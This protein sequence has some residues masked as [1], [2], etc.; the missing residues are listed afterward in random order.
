MSGSSASVSLPD[1]TKLFPLPG[2]VLFPSGVL[3]LHIFEPRYRQ[4]VEDA[5]RGDRQVTL[6]LP[7]LEKGDEPIPIAPVGCIGTIHRVNRLPDG[8]FLLSLRGGH[9]VR[10]LEE[11]PSGRLYRVARIQPL[12]DRQSPALESRRRLQRAHVVSCLR[13]LIYQ[14]D[15]AEAYLRFIADKQSSSVFADL[16]AS[17]APLPI[18]IKQQL[19][20][21]ADVDRRMEL[22]A[23]A[24]ES[25][26][27]EPMAA[28]PPPFALN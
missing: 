22:L 12:L 17:A 18:Q 28:L 26:V 13:G 27:K 10:L 6:V 11:V 23:E 14:H 8:R 9:R 19:L 15:E 16:V 3:P 21:A 1:H 25:L 7:T 4:M 2:T 24:M 5:L 20:E